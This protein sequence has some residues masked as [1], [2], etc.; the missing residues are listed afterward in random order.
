MGTAQWAL[1]ISGVAVSISL[2]NLWWN[3]R[4]RYIHPKPRIGVRLE[5]YLVGGA[6]DPEG[7][8]VDNYPRVLARPIAGQSPSTVRSAAFRSS[9][10]SLAK[11]FSIGLK[12]GLYGG[13]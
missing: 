10:L 3:I 1:I 9:A 13:R 11:A 5:A 7:W 6:I 2:V 4:S 8:R 12:S